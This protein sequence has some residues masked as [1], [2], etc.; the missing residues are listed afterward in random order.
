MSDKTSRKRFVELLEENFRKRLFIKTNWGHNQVM[1]EFKSAI[2][3]TLLQLEDEK[4]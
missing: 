1:V 4:D 2:V 3:D